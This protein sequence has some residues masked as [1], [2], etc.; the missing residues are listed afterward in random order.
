MDKSHVCVGGYLFHNV[1]F[2]VCWTKIFIWLMIHY[3]VRTSFYWDT[4]SQSL[5]M[6]LPGLWLNEHLL[7]AFTCGSCSYALPLCIFISVYYH[8]VRVTECLDTFMQFCH[9]WERILVDSVVRSIWISSSRA[10]FPMRW[11]RADITSHT[12][13]HSP[14]FHF[15]PQFFLLCNTIHSILAAKP[16][17]FW[18]EIPTLGQSVPIYE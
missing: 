5:I 10:S 15:Y 6:T 4:H 16:G 17:F 11:D 12:H 8:A 18:Q 9:P 3:F 13:T 14:T 1:S 7:V 2:A